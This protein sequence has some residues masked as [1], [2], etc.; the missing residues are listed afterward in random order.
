MHGLTVSTEREIAE[1]QAFLDRAYASL[2]PMERQ[3]LEALLSQ[4][5]IVI[6]GCERIMRQPIPQPWN[7]WGCGHRCGRGEV[8]W[9]QCMCLTAS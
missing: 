9:V 3:Q 8:G 4:C 5:D 6:G 7:R 2:H 1:E